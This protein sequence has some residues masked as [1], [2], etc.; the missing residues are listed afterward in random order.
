MGENSRKNSK[1]TQI[2]DVLQNL[3]QNGKSPLSAGFTRWRLEREWKK[4]VGAEFSQS[5]TPVGFQNGTLWLWVSHP[6]FIQHLRFFEG[7]I[8]EKVN[9][10]LG[11]KYAHRV[12]F[13]LDKKGMIQRSSDES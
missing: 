13:T 7:Q 2:S 5:C 10:Y 3:F 11:Y 4:V 1:P 6:G 12:G 9:Q 8:L